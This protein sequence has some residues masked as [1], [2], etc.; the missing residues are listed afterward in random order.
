[1]CPFVNQRLDSVKHSEK[2][3]VAILD[4]SD[5][6]FNDPGDPSYYDLAPYPFDSENR[7]DYR[8]HGSISDRENFF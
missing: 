8:Q 3:S 6:Y 4:V 1:M 7:I 5:P 2:N